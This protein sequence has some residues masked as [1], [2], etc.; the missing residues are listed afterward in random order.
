[1][2]EY[3]TPAGYGTAEFTEKRSR[4]I[5]RVWP[6]E[7]VGAALD[8][9][10]SAKAQHRDARHN[11]WCYLLR[12]GGARGSDDGEPQGTAGAPMLEVFKRGGITD[13]CCVA[14]RY[15]GGILL[16]AGGLTRAYGKAAKL[17]LD[18]AGVERRTVRR[19][20]ELRCPYRYAERLR[21]ETRLL[22]GDVESAQYGETVTMR[23]RIPNGSADAFMARAADVSAGAAIIVAGAED[24]GGN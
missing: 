18:A 10:A 15:F 24:G 22:G 6:A 17:A 1:M 9:V 12:D 11:C 21:A 5:G 7:T 13:V 14:T 23:I 8:F 4:F 2:S 20:V 16:G 3:L 19:V